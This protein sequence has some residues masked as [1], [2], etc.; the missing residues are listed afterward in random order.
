MR[1]RF[2]CNFSLA[3]LKREICHEEWIDMLSCTGT[4]TLNGITDRELIQIL[5]SKIK[6]EGK[7][8]FNPQLLQLS[9]GRTSQETSYNN[10]IFTWL[11]EE[12]LKA[13][14]EITGLLLSGQG[15]QEA[16]R[17]AVAA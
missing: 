17:P 10:A 7:F 6:N 14:H 5:E 11:N 9:Q 8:N 13:I 2:I 12:G 16:A 4:I 1:R 3:D 15:K